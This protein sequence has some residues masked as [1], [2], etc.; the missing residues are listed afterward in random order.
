M[1]N[2]RPLGWIIIAINLL[3]LLNFVSTLGKVS[4]DLAIGVA[5]LF[6]L[7]LSTVI[8]VPLY[9][10]YKITGKKK[11][12]CPACGVNV[13]IGLTVC[14]KCLYDFRKNLGDSKQNL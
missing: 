14:Q 10:V 7:F 3:L 13:P 9:I 5:F 12:Q 8:S 4:S 6:T 1:K 11:R 2:I